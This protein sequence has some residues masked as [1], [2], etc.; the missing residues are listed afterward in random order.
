VRLEQVQFRWMGPEG[1]APS[2]G[3]NPALV[4][5]HQV[6]FCLEEEGIGR[7]GWPGE[8][9]PSQTQN[10]GERT[11]QRCLMERRGQEKAQEGG[12]GQAALGK[13]QGRKSGWEGQLPS[14]YPSTCSFAPQALTT[15][16]E[17]LSCLV[18]YLS[19][20]PLSNPFSKP[21]EYS[22]EGP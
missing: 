17:L 5:T 2:P 15:A 19:H 18:F 4:Q 12:E 6:L 21:V 11:K 9:T 3:S 7:V 1:R 22:P 10:Y 16:S 14:L 8:R 13:S 20:I